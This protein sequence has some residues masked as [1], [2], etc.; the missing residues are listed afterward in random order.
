MRM[1]SI[2]SGSSGNCIYAG[3]DNHH[4]LIDAGI[5]CKRVEAGLKDLELSGKDIDGILLTHEHSDHI[6]GLGVLARKYGFPIHATQGTAEAV[7]AMSSLGKID[8]SLFVEIHADQ[9]FKIGD[10]SISPFHISHDAAEPVAYRI[11]C[12]EK[13]MAVATDLGVYTDYTIDHLKGLDVLLLE[14]NHDIHMLQ[15]GAYP[16]Y[17]QQR[18]SGDLGHLSNET[19]GKLL[20]EVL[21]GGLKAV[22]LGHLSKENNYA[23][24][25]YETVKLELLLGD[26]SYQAKEIPLSV[27]SREER[28]ACVVF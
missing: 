13:K 23:E 20:C 24:L 8:S 1:C 17:L 26:A 22:M 9:E 10:L 14:A 21:H 15:V 27:A 2:A 19:A 3:S 18:I 5:S 25:A 6:K 11:S 28:S 7:K 16:Y 4:I 12:G